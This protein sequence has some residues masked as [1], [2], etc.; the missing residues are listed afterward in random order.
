MTTSVYVGLSGQLALER[1]MATIAN[2]VA[3]AGT[4]GYRAEGVHFST[5]VSRT[6]PFHTA[7]A[8]EGGA[9]A[10]LRGGGL[11]RTGN[12]LDVAIQGEG[13]LSIQTPAGIAYTRDGRMQVLPSGD[14]VSLNGHAILDASGSPLTLDPGGGP[15]EIARDGSISQRGK[16]SGVIGLFHI[17]LAKPYSRYENAAFL[18][19][20]SGEPVVDFVADGVA[21]GFIEESNVN[22]IAEMSNLIRVSR[23]FEMVSSGLEQRDAALRDAIPALGGR[24]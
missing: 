16:V 23:A 10:D 19:A 6:A 8:S 11:S 1:R 5:V 14:V 15:P 21:Q 4:A 13:F 12:P 2:N 17:D 3:N 24:S 18:T 22:A 9:F 7:F 20:E